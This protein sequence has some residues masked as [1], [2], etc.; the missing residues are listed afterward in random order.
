MQPA[1]GAS[2]LPWFVLSWANL[3]GLGGLAW[4]ETAKTLRYLVGKFT[5]YRLLLTCVP[6]RIDKLHSLVHRT[7]APLS[8]CMYVCIV[9]TYSRV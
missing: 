1:A 7:G 8:D 3:A 6:V 9:I 2:S 5:V 4:S